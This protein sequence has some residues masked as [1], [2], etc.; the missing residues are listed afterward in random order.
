MFR[1][2]WVIIM[3]RSEPSDFSGIITYSF[4]FWRL[5]VGV[6]WCMAYTDMNESLKTYQEVLLGKPFN[7]SV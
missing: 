6:K 2:I 4:L 7:I 3:L 1:L 5:L